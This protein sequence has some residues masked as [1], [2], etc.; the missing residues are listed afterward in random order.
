M[1]HP[2]PVRQVRACHLEQVEPDGHGC[3]GSSRPVVGVEVDQAG[4]RWGCRQDVD[5]Q[6]EAAQA[7]DGGIDPG[8]GLR[9]VEEAG[10]LDDGD[11]RAGL[12]Q[13]VGEVAGERAVAT[14]QRPQAHG[15]T[16]VPGSRGIGYGKMPRCS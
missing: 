10:R 9:P 5:E 2:A 6:V 16:V 1:D 12:R 7:G 13:P 3:L 11:V 8:G 15:P 4:G 14:Q